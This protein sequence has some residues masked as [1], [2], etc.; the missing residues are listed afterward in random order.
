MTSSLNNLNFSIE[1]KGNK[2][3]VVGNGH[4]LPISHIGKSYVY[5]PNLKTRAV[6]FN[7]VLCVPLLTKNLV[8]I[9]KLT[10]DSNAYA[11][12]DHDS[13]IIKDKHTKRELLKGKLKQGLINFKLLE[14]RGIKLLSL[15]TS[16]M[17]IT[18]SFIILV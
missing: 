14:I 9:S 12:F 16:K 2:K 3:L 10:Q 15:G 8:S 5:S 17:V 7:D 18:L 11:I 6:A 13:C 1:F 4:Q